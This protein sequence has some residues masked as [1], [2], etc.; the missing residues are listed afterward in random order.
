MACLEWFRNSGRRGVCEWGGGE[1]AKEDTEG[2]RE[3]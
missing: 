2:G 1:E 3:E